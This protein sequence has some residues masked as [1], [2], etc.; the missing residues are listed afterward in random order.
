M[1]A[2]GR[3]GAFCGVVRLPYIEEGAVGQVEVQPPTPVAIGM[4]RPEHWWDRGVEPDLASEFRLFLDDLAEKN[5]ETRRQAEALASGTGF[6]HGVADWHAFIKGVAERFTESVKGWR[7][8]YE[9]V[10]GAWRAEG[11][12]TSRGQRSRMNALA[13][14]ARELR[15]LTVVEEL[16]NRKFLPRYGFPIGLNSLLVNVARDDGGRFRL[17]R[18]GAVAVAEYLP[19]S[20]IVVGGQFVQSHGVQRAL[21]SE[22]SDMV[23]IT[24]WRHRCEEGHSKCLPVLEPPEERC[25]VDGCTARMVKRPE[26]LLVPRYGYATAAWDPP[27]W[28]G[29]RHRV[30]EVELVINHAQG[31]STMSEVDFGGLSGLDAE[32]LENVELLAANSGARR[33]GFAVCTACG[34]S[35]SVEVARAEGAMN[36]PKGFEAH[37]PLYRVS[38]APCR[39]ATGKA[40][41]LRNITFSARQFT[42]VVRSEFTDVAGIDPVSLT[43]LGHALAQGAAEILELDQREIRMAVDP[44]GT[45]RSVVRVFD[46][47]GHGGGHMAE[48][49][50]RSSEW[51]PAVHRTL[52]RSEAHHQKC[53]TACITC[54]LSS[55][56]Q[57]DASNGLLDRNAALAVLRGAGEPC[58]SPLRT[59]AGSD[60]VSPEQSDM[61]AIL[62]ARKNAAKTNQRRR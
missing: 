30:G 28:Y 2:F 19:G 6:A 17:Q 40:A 39:D 38:G 57:E 43:T 54:V 14:Q 52:Y 18:E 59:D 16:G 41:I 36:L 34:F 32:F 9:R 8:D 51:L 46:A 23:G 3:T 56:S 22:E 44:V 58:R 29:Q 21:G 50:H 42:D 62:K 12:G 47:V 53:R 4:I 20:V 61:L 37:L 11:Q 1:D 24:L 15:D 26:R 13:R 25:G 35:T 49:F 5:G 48:L 33:V 45:G 27:S 7:E 10:V 55:V 60:P 31:R